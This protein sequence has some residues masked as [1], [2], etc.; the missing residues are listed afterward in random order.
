MKPSCSFWIVAALLIHFVAPAIA[1]DPAPIK[2]PLSA[3]DA[4]KG[5]VLAS[6]DL[7][8]ELV[9]SEPEV[10]DPVAIAFG[11]DGCM[12][13]VEMRDYPYGPKPGSGDRPKSRITRLYDK[14]RDGRF[15]SSA[16]YVDE[17]LFPTGVL[18][19]KDGIIVTLA[20]EIAFFADRDGDGRAEFKE[21]WFT[22]FVQENSQLRANHPTFGPDGWIYVANGLRGGTIVAAKPEWKAKG[23]PVALAGFDFRFNPLTGEAGAVSGNGQFGLCFDDYGNRFICSNRNPVQHVVLED[24]YIKR[25][26]FLAVKK[27]VQDV[28]A[29]AEHSRLHPISRAWTTSTLHA[30]QFTAACGVQ[31]YRGDALPPEFVGNAFT[32]DPTGNLVHREVLTASGASFIGHPS[33]GDQEFLASADTWFRPVNLSNG[34]DGALYVVDMYRA[35]IEHPDWMPAELKTRRDLLDGNDRGRIWRITSVEPAMAQDRPDEPLNKLPT[36]ELIE[37]LE[38]R[39]AWQRDASMRILLERNPDEVL[40]LLKLNWKQNKLTRSR[41]RVLWMLKIL[42]PRLTP[43]VLAWSETRNRDGRV[44]EHIAAAIGDNL[45]ELLGEQAADLVNEEADERVRFR[46]ALDLSGRSEDGVAERKLLIQLVDH[47]AEDP[48]LRL[49]VATTR[50]NPPEALIVELLKHWQSRGMTPDGGVE[51]IEELCEVTGAQIAAGASKSL[52]QSLLAFESPTLSSQVVHDLQVAGLRGFGQGA[53]RRGVSLQS[54][55]DQLAE[56]DRPLLSTLLARTTNTI[57]DTDATPARRLAA[58][59]MLRFVTS[60]GVAEALLEVALS[61]EDVAL[62]LAALDALTTSTSMAVGPKLLTAFDSQTPQLRRAMLDVLLADEARS[63]L[64]LDALEKGNLKTTEVDVTRQGRLTKHRN[65]AL[66]ARAGKLFAG[67]ISADRAAVLAKYEAA[68]TMKGDGPRGRAI[69]EKNCVT[70]HR[71]ANSGTNV[72]PDIGDSRDKT[73]AYLLTNILDP[74]RAVDANYFG[75]T[76]VTNSG[77]ILTGLIKSETAS[78]ITIRLPEGK[79]ETILRADV[80]ELKSSGLSLMPVGLEKTITVEQMAD[81]ISFLK[82]WRYLDGV[83]PLAE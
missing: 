79:E 24:Q 12:W 78:S 58:M 65:S 69:F 76:L 6:T 7:K 66:A 77:K 9:A 59:R 23:Q 5:F 11:N 83:V 53:A 43:A 47:G 71:V 39:N 82:N 70:C 45:D 44:R 50:C 72:G 25:N 16:V 22:G 67:A 27:A 34:P 52:F 18:P 35:V 63:N 38:H 80:D 57:S 3:D 33:D 51:L 31:I 4:Q 64:L 15:E 10:V 55:L 42:D 20:G 26:P 54:H 40:D 17:L 81:L 62:R 28:A 48:W 8:I 14:N 41:L 74:N 36:K 2:S 29:F 46:L 1:Q 21:T 60:P 30:N 68:L 61:D 37:L 73:P 19:W 75:Y 32:C 13:V 49:A 56:S